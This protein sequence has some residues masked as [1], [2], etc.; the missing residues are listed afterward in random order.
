MAPRLTLTAAQ[1]TLLHALA[2]GRPRTRGDLVEH[3]GWTRNTVATRLEELIGLEWVIGNEEPAAGRGRPPGLFTLNAERALVFVASFGHTHATWALTDL[4]GRTLS[5]RTE[6]LDIG[7]GPDA[8]TMKTRDVAKELFTEARRPAAALGSVVVGLPSPIHSVTRRPIN[9]SVMPGWL[10][11]DVL[12]GFR[13]ALGVPVTVENDAKLMTLGTKI[14]HFPD[15]QDLI[16]IKI[17]T[18]IGAGI[19]SGGVL[20]RGVLGMAGEIGHLRIAASRKPCACG[21][22]GCVGVHVS[23]GGITDALAESGIAVSGLDD[24]VALANR[25]DADCA[26]VLR[27][28]G[29]QLGEVVAA[30]LATINPE[31]VALGGLLGSLGDDLLAGMRE[32]LYALAHPSLTS[33]LH[34]VALADHEIAAIR[35]AAHLGLSDILGRSPGDAG[36]AA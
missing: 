9:P 35:G 15:V 8:A 24:I 29:R 5:S 12:G 32:T 22:V 30:L 6:P 17:A 4:L 26:R 33:S 11:A 20:Q 25:G 3:S 23:T 1:K 28:A 14:R 31:V 16:F 2:D 18:G 27:Q 34:T 7:V 36:L 19:V 21:N 10:G 13:G